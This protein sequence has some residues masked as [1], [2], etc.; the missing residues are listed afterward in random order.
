MTEISALPSEIL[1]SILTQL[2]SASLASYASVCRKWQVLIEKQTF[3]HLLLTS[4]RLGDF[5]RI[6]SSSS[7]R[8]CLIRYLD[9]YILLP[10]YEIA[11]RTQLESQIDRQK[12]NEAFTQT[13]VSFWDIL[14]TWAEEDVA[15]LSL[16]IRARSSSD[17]GAEPD[18]KK[19]MA[20]RRWGRK[21]PKKDWLD[22]R[23]YQSYLELITN[24][25]ILPELSCVTQFIV[26]CRG[27]RTIAPA[28]VSKLLSRL[29]GAQIVHASLS[30]N[31]RKDP[32][33]RD[34]LRNEFALT[35]SNWPSTIQHLCLEYPGLPPADGHFPPLRRS[36]PWADPLSLA[37][38]HLTQQLVTVELDKIMIGPEFFWP[39]LHHPYSAPPRWPRLTSLKLVYQA[40]TPSGQWL[41]EKDPRC[42]PYSS[43]Q[44]EDV[45][46]CGTREDPRTPAPQD[47]YPDAFR[48]KPADLLND[49]HRAAGQAAQHMPTLKTM[50]LQAIPQLYP[51]GMA[52]LHTEAATESHPSPAHDTG[53]WFRYDRGRSTATWVSSGKFSLLADT[54]NTWRQVGALHGHADFHLEVGFYSPRRLIFGLFWLRQSCGAFMI[55][56]N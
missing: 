32:K 24:P 34:Q 50:F 25:A 3:S 44:R 2:G 41:F 28:T 15:G 47:R 30:D 18:E 27:H 8:R 52:H 16:N 5:K 42:Q 1:S 33:L 22:W 55:Q 12:N 49:L 43:S 51:P 40:V 10:A 31:E 54:V 26:T 53:H 23:F 35:V 13:I 29:P 20:R 45:Y 48:S 6:I 46:E 14:S 7:H 21:F 19:R 56:G 38:N 36:E 4:D 11:A 17:C 37:L 39:P 9:L